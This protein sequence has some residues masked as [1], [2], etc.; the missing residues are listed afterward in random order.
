MQNNYEFVIPVTVLSF[1]LPINNVNV[2]PVTT[3]KIKIS[4]EVMCIMTFISPL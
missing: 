1:L 2:H 3:I 4:F